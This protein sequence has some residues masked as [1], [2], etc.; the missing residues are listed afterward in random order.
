MWTLCTAVT[1]NDLLHS[2]YALKE[3]R[4]TMCNFFKLN[5]TMLLGPANTLELN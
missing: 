4:Q 3:E 5:P 2:R 1:K